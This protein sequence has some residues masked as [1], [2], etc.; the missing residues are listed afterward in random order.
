MMHLH[1]KVQL[2]CHDYAVCLSSVV[3]GNPKNNLLRAQRSAHVSFTNLLV[4]NANYCLLL[5]YSLKMQ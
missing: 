1:C 3:I 4:V 2:Y 5:L